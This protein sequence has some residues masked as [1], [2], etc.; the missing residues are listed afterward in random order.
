RAPATPPR[1]GRW[2]SADLDGATRRI[3][4]RRRRGARMSA[5]RTAC[6]VLALAAAIGITADAAAQYGGAGGGPGRGGM[7][8]M[9]GQ[10]GGPSPDAVHRDAMADAP[11]N[12]GA[13]VQLELDRIEDD[14]KMTPA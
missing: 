3:H 8:G 9:G 14:L 10:R 7:G 5:I 1:G 11:L 4:P 2:R 13:V 12:P 6:G